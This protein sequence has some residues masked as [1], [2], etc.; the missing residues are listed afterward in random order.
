MS[1]TSLLLLI[2]FLLLIGGLVYLS[3][4]DTRQAP[5]RIEQDISNEAFAR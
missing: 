1:R 2:L 5:Q 4:I 3:T